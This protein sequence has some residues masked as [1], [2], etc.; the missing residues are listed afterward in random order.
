ML[1]SQGFRHRSDR[2]AE[3]VN[4]KAAFHRCTWAS[5]LA[6]RQF[7]RRWGARWLVAARILALVLRNPLHGSMINRSI[8]LTMA[9]DLMPFG[10]PSIISVLI[11]P[12]AAIDND[13]APDLHPDEEGGGK[14][15]GILMLLECKPLLVFAAALALSA[16]AGVH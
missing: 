4:H 1:L 7:A 16:L 3:K 2:P 11:I 12:G 8:V 13:A 9:R 14:V 10:A 5:F 15:G 6:S